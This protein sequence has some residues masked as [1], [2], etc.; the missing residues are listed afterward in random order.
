MVPNQPNFSSHKQCTPTHQENTSNQQQEQVKKKKNTP[1]VITTCANKRKP[2]KQ[3]NTFLA[4]T[5]DPF[6][7][8]TTTISSKRTY[9]NM[10]LIRGEGPLWQATQEDPICQTNEVGSRCC[11][12][13]WGLSRTH[14]DSEDV[15]SFCF[16]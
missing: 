7:K 10:N 1:T 2:H 9:T 4:S 8:K 15:W 13:S 6:Y 16:F 11:R 12:D 3:K 14:G 5:R